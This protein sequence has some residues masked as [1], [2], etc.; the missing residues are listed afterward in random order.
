M[1]RASSS[2]ARFST[3]VEPTTTTT[4]SSSSSSIEIIEG[5]EKIPT[6]WECNEDAECVEIPACDE[7]VCRTSLDVRIHNTW[8]NLSGWRKAHPA[9][10][11]W[12]DW[13]DGRDATDVMDAFHSKKGREMY[14]RLPKS[15]DETIAVLEASVAPYSQTEINFRKLRDQLEA[16]GWWDRDYV[17]EAT[18]LGIWASLVVG[19]AVTAESAP[20]LSTFLLALSMTNA[21]WL[22]MIIFTELTSSPMS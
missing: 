18:L 11:H 1:P 9:G 10:A 5:E 12:I 20:P 19:A 21:G 13:Y 22:D 2:T 4:T 15:S 17:H 6:A 8:Y 7:E 3:V 16:D 14:K